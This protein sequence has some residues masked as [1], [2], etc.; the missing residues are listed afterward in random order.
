[1]PT[2]QGAVVLTLIPLLY[3]TWYY[4]VNRIV[5]EPY[6]DEV[7]HVRQAQAYYAGK[8]QTWDPKIT[9]PPG[10]YLLSYLYL[11]T[12]AIVSNGIGADPPNLRWLNSLVATFVIPAQV[13]FLYRRLRLSLHQ[14]QHEENYFHTIM[15]LSL[16]P[17]LFFFSG[18]YYTDVCSVSLVLF[19][20][21][22]HL[23]YLRDA[24]GGRS[25]TGVPMFALGLCA[26]VMRQ[27]NI[28]WVA[29]F[30]A[31]LHAVHHVKSINQSR[32]DESVEMLVALEAIHDPPIS[33]AYLEGMLY[34]A[35][36]ETIY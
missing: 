34:E 15:N 26:L 20:Y 9:T 1:M 5:S 29:V 17:V 4:Q 30:F 27:T 21:E 7:F 31:G 14:G 36:Q 25:M 8:I 28:F 10:L 18:L 3:A 22:S 35:D 12:R 33:K 13:W 19:A 11:R 32:S 16:F 2:L 6:L 23:R 24:S